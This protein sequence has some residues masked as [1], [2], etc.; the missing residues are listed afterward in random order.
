MPSLSSR[1]VI[2]QLMNLS[3]HTLCPCHG[4]RTSGPIA[5]HAINQFRKF[6]TP[7]ELAP[8]KEY[9]FEVAAS[10]LRFGAG[11][12]REVGMDFANVKATKVCVISFV[13]RLCVVRINFNLLRLEFLR[14]LTSQGSNL[15]KL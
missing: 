9:A 6:A 3:R 2:A 4:C 12:T 13:G 10:N 1:A 14:M 15:S 5:S 7:V 11:V 8:E